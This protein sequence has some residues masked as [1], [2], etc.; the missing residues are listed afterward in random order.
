MRSLRTRQWV[1]GLIL[2]TGCGLLLLS[3]RQQTLPLRA[4]LAGLPREML[5][6]RGTDIVLDPREQAIAGMSS[7]AMRAFEGGPGPAFQIY[8]GYYESQIQGKTIHS[9]KNCLP[10]AGWEP[11]SAGTTRI[12]LARDT[13]TVNR[14]LLGKGS[15]TALVY[16]WYQGRG[17]V[18]ANEYLVKWNLLRDKALSG[19]SEE[20]LVRILVPF[21]G[22]TGAADSLATRVAQ[23]LILQVE[24]RLPGYPGRSVL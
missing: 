5:G 1:A 12:P 9:P 7:Y 11:I 8:V 2:T 17:R 18:A 23:D 24:S 4:P 3:S 22:P 19:R 10:G 15:Q 21:S 16:Y 6:Y 20:T 13:V 14:Y